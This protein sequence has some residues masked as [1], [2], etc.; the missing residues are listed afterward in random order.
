MLRAF[1]L[2]LTLATT[3]F[4][5]ACNEGSVDPVAS[6]GEITG[7]L[8]GVCPLTEEI[9]DVFSPGGLRNAVTKQC[10]NIAGE[11][12]EGD[13]EGA[14]EK[15]FS[16]ID[17]ILGHH[18]DGETTGDDVATAT[19][20]NAL[21]GIVNLDGI[22]PVTG[23]DENTGGGSCD[24]GGCTHV[25]QSGLAGISVPPQTSE[26]IDQCYITF[27]LRE[28][29]PELFSGFDNYPFQF[30]YEIVCADEAT[31]GLDLA[32]DGTIYDPAAIV[33][34]CFADPPLGPTTEE[35][36]NENRQLAH[37]PDGEE[38]PVLLEIAEATFLTDEDCAEASMAAAPLPYRALAK[39][40]P[41]S[42]FFVSPLLANPGRLGGAIAAH[43]PIG[44]VDNRG[45]EDDLIPTT[46]NL[47]LEDS[48]SCCGF[49]TSASANVSEDI[50]DGGAVFP[51]D[52]EFV[53]DEIEGDN[54]QTTVRALDDGG[55]ADL[56]IVCDGEPSSEGQISVPLGSFTV[57][58]N[59]QGT[60]T[61]EASSSEPEAFDC[62]IG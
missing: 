10:Q 27:N 8:K 6:T 31:G 1:L 25:T 28:F 43:S 39:L 29:D 51:G 60:E 30:E 24:S 52:V 21:L 54:D 59:F 4:I 46:T 17:K 45:V 13:T 55:G 9:A 44:P 12:D 11:L 2:S 36:P 40:E 7:A 57:Q 50:V 5:L 35:V 34:V 53:I 48:Q 62:V 49:V 3:G 22:F 33:G 38:V 18:A 58:A 61:H 19:L 56:D 26:G 23:V 37:L 32:Q 14:V 47:G 41:I 16:L 42:E 15:V 20:L